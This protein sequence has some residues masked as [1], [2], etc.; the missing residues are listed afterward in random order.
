M[1]DR[2]QTV[3]AQ[4][5]LP[6]HL[7]SLDYL[8]GT[9]ILLV[10]LFHGYGSVD[11][12]RMLGT[13]PGSLLD[14]LVG[15]CNYG[16]HLF[17]LLSGFL[18][19]TILLRG[20]SKPSYYREFYIKRALRILPVFVVVLIT[21]KIFLPISWRFFFASCLFLSNFAPLFGAPSG[22]YGPLWSL[23]VEEHFYLLWPSCVRHLKEV[24]LLP[25]LA[26]VIV[27]EPVLR[28]LAIRHNAHIDIRFKTPFLLDYIAYGALLATLLHRGRIH[29][30][31][32]RR[33]AVSLLAMSAPLVL[34][35]LYLAAFHNSNSLVA[36]RAL[37]WMWLCAG[38]LL[39]GLYR[40][41]AR[42]G[43]VGAT[44]RTPGFLGFLAYISYGLYLFQLFVSEK[45]WRL[46]N[47]LLH[48]LGLSNLTLQS[49]AFL[50]CAS[51]SVLVAYLSR[52]FFEQPFLNLKSRLLG[53][54]VRE[55]VVLARTKV[56]VV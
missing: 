31:N 52:R 2:T 14:A 45:L 12:V 41:A 24:K 27:L 32:I 35:T 40:D 16:V 46:V 21:L 37:P 11:W 8:R 22:E 43:R 6:R 13:V 17:F 47:E 38:M 3:R 9:A 49:G 39:F 48:H 15:E 55:E 56:E 28:V 7:P 53:Q 18:I 36:L 51:V 10:L 5:V 30:A 23:C 26:S 25:L 34:L 20:R 19:T 33:V 1:T 4:F 29:Q 50:V 44:E 54:P 42:T